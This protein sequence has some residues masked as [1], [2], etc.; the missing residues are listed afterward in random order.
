[1]KLIIYG[2]LDNDQNQTGDYAI[3]GEAEV[4]EVRETYSFWKAI[5]R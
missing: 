4:S 5:A 2:A 1:M 3:L